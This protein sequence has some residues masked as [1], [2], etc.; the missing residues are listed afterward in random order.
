MVKQTRAKVNRNSKYSD[1][2]KVEIKQTE[3][4][5]TQ[6]SGDLCTNLVSTRMLID[7]SI[8]KMYDYVTWTFVLCYQ[9]DLC[10]DTYDTG[11]LGLLPGFQ[12]EK[13][14]PYGAYEAQEDYEKCC[15]ISLVKAI[16][17]IVTDASNQP[18][19]II[20]SFLVHCKKEMILSVMNS[21]IHPCF[22]YLL[23]K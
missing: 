1:S 5:K 12:D 11:K 6:V 16:L 7:T 20:F 13:C 3:R 15:K 2:W 4:V 22:E 14:K 17:N 21:W 10:R 19:S 18:D 23:A 8:I 9:C